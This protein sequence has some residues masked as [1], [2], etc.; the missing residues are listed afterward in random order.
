MSKPRTLDNNV[1]TGAL[2]IEV[3]NDFM[4]TMNKIIFDE[5]L[6]YNNKNT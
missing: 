6:A 1:E 5:Y 4:R 2:I 3:K